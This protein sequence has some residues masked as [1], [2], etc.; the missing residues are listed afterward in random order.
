MEVLSPGGGTLQLSR[1]WTVATVQGVDRC[2][3]RIFLEEW[4]NNAGL[5]SVQ[6]GRAVATVQGVDRCNCP[7]GGPLQQSRGWTV[8]AHGSF[9]KGGR[10]KQVCHLLALA[11]RS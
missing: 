4:P 10:M 2:S 9:S 7:G 6:P 1:G 3:P 8:A 5:S 11:D